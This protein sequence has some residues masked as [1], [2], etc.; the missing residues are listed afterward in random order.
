M[1]KKLQESI[2]KS[3]DPL[4]TGWGIHII[5]SPNKTAI[6]WL[7]T[8]NV[9]SRLL[10]SILWTKLKGDL[11][12]AFAIGAWVISVPTVLMLAFVIKWSDD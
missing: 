12:G 10:L 4:P 1:P 5:E 8:L 9:C 6:F 7:M 11:K 3:S 2:L